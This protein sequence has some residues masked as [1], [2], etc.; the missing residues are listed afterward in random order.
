[1]QG[2]AKFAMSGKWNSYVDMAPCNPDGSAIP[3]APVRRLWT[4]AEKPEEDHYGCTHFAWHLNSTQYLSK[5]PLA[6]DSRRRADRQALQERKMTEAAAE[7]AA[8]D[9]QQQQQ[10]KVRGRLH[11]RFAAGRVRHRSE[12]WKVVLTHLGI[13]THVDRDGFLHAASLTAPAGRSNGEQ[14]RNLPWSC[15][16]LTCFLSRC[17]CRCCCRSLSSGASSGRR[18]G[19]SR[20]LT[21]RC[22]ALQNLFEAEAVVVPQWCFRRRPSAV[23]A[24][25]QITEAVLGHWPHLIAIADSSPGHSSTAAGSSSSHPVAA[26]MLYESERPAC[27]LLLLLQILDGEEPADVVPLWRWNGKYSSMR[28][29]MPAGSDGWPGERRVCALLC[30]LWCVGCSSGPCTMHAVGVCAQA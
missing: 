3:D 25:W 10:H 14:Q 6:S 20:H 21:C 8:L 9:A 19:L 17:C 1:M 13:A 15:N 12:A 2:N 22:A 18:G 24:S 27:V 16:T 7:K 29:S 26:M 4:C 5:A 23:T 11:P 30:G 28:D